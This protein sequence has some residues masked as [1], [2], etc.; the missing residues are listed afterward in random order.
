[1]KIPKLIFS[2]VLITILGSS[3]ST[4]RSAN[5][6]ISVAVFPEDAVVIVNGVQYQGTPLIMPVYRGEDAIIQVYSP[7]YQ[8]RY[9]VVRRHLS[10][11]GILDCAGAILLFPPLGLLSGGAYDFDTNNIYIN[12]S[13][14]STNIKVEN[15]PE[16]LKN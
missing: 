14:V 1:M 12:M 8:T 13:D 10:T 16:K 7:Q 15:D 5:E 2:L 4:F 6:T 3:C 9:F 11:T